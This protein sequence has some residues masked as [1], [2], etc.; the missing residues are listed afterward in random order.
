MTD[1]RV[2]REAGSMTV[3][4]TDEQIEA[5]A[6][7]P[8]RAARLINPKTN[9]VFVLV[10]A[11]EFERVRSLLE[12]DFDLRETY[13]AQLAAAMRAGWDDPAMDDYNN[14][15]EAYKKLCQSSEAKSS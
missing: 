2:T 8:D 5:V 6:R 9:E 7:Q 14:Y 11:E 13:T 12:V 1:S 10:P 15:D 3:A 4:L